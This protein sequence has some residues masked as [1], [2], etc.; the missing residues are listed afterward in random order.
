VLRKAAARDLLPVWGKR[1]A[2]AKVE[3]LKAKAA[4]LKIQ[5][6]IIERLG[7]ADNETAHGVHPRSVHLTGLEVYRE[8]QKIDSLF[9]VLCHKL[10]LDV[11]KIAPEGPRR[12]DL[13]QWEKLTE[14]Q[15]TALAVGLNF[16]GT[17]FR[18]RVPEELYA[19]AKTL[20]KNADE[21]I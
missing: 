9:F 20:D 8:P 11:N 21:E 4:R 15:R 2:D 16:S 17:G 13:A 12:V 14:E 6:H 7:L 5:N 3:E 10:G 1:W 18:V 19:T